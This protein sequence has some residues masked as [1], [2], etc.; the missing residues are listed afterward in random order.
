MV[1]AG[2]SAVLFVGG[3]LLTEFAGVPEFFGDTDFKPFFLA[4]LLAALLPY[5]AATL[6]VGF[7]MALGEGILD[8]VEGYAADDPFGFVGYVVGLWAFAYVLHELGDPD[9]RLHMSV[10]AI[11]GAFVQIAIEGVAYLLIDGETLAF[12]AI[13]VFGNT[14][15]HGVVLGFVPLLFVYPL[16]HG[17][18][19]RYLGFAPQ[20]RTAGN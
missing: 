18:L 2:I 19:E 6:S 3:L 4:Y 13:N 16:L 1:I 5:G 12:Y 11:V 17:R 20:G 10:A 8:V 15:T 14:V 7:G 9:N